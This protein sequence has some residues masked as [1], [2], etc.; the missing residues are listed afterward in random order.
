[1]LNVED[2][3]EFSDVQFVSCSVSLKVECEFD[4]VW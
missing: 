4:V 1:M 2:E 3:R